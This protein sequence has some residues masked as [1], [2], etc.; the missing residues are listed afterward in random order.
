MEN[1]NVEVRR[2]LDRIEA[3]L[4]VVISLSGRGF[5]EAIK[6]EAGKQSTDKNGVLVLKQMT[7]RQHATLQLLIAG[8]SNG[9]IA[10]VLGVGENTVK[11]HVRALCDK[12]GM[13]NRSQVGIKGYELLS[14]IPPDDYKDVSGGLPK[15]WAATLIDGEKDPYSHVYRR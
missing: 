13:N 14:T 3:K 5:V 1:E 9:K 2:Q 15:D 7:P 11:V 6:P 10:S 8:W 4:D 12:L